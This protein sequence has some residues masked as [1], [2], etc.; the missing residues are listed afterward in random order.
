[1]NKDLDKKTIKQITN[2]TPLGRMGKPE[3]VADL[4]A[5]LCDDKADFITGQII[6]IDGGLTL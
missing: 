5:F 2:E 3:E 4:V 6:T 1:M